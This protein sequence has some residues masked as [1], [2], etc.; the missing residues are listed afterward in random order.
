MLGYRVQCSC[1]LK[2]GTTGGLE[3]EHGIR[4]NQVRIGGSAYEILKAIDG[5]EAKI[6]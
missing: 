2:G 3:G 6:V 1:A 4:A 5:F